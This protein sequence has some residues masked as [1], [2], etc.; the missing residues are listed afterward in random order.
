MNYHLNIYYF[1]ATWNLVGKE[2]ESVDQLLSTT[3]LYKFFGQSTE[4]E[5]ENHHFLQGE[6]YFTKKQGGMGISQR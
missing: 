4:H 2:K 3:C 6:N 1:D 5:M